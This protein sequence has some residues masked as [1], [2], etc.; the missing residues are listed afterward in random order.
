MGF[1][2]DKMLEKELKRNPE[3]KELFEKHPEKVE[4]YRQKMQ[5]VWFEGGGGAE[6]KN[7]AKHC[8]TCLF[9]HGQPPYADSPDKCHCVIFEYPNSKPTEVYYDGEPC[10]YYEKKN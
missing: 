5:D 9:A 7:K 1:D 3:L 10:E 4:Q 2:F 6:N 8:Q